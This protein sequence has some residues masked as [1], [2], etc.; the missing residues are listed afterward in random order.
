MALSNYKVALIQLHPK[1]VDPS[2]NF[3]KAANFIRSAAQ[4]GAN[5]AVLPEYH[6]TNWGESLRTAYLIL[7]P[8]VGRIKVLEGTSCSE[9][10]ISRSNVHPLLEMLTPSL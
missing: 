1:K 10:H 2:F 7:Q 6:L 4:Q 9:R 8:S 3:E 5:L